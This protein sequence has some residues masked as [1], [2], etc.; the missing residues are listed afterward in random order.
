[1]NA[2]LGFESEKT[3]EFK[4]RRFTFGFP[5]IRQEVKIESKKSEFTEG[6]YLEIFKN[7]TNIAFDTIE[8]VNAFATV[9]VLIPGIAEGLEVGSLM[10]LNRSVGKDIVELY[11]NEI[12]PFLDAIENSIDESIGQEEEE[13]NDGK[14]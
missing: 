8:R 10:D 13:G 1:M 3:V 6:N 4:G 2:T 7:Q 9:E 5:T 12:V 11:M 14:K